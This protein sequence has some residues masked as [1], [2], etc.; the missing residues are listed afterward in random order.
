MKKKNKIEELTGLRKMGKIEQCLRYL[1]HKLVR[2]AWRV[3]S[4]CY[5]VYC[6]TAI[7][8][9]VFPLFLVLPAVI[10]DNCV[11]CFSDIKSEFKVYSIS[12]RYGEYKSFKE[13]VRNALSEE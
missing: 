3:A 8:S 11:S 12:L 7:L 4:S 10:I 2:L 13:R 1:L 6:L 9:T 5:P